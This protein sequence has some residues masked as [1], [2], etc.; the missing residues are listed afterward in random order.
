MANPDLGFSPRS[1]RRRA[2]EPGSVSG[3]VQ[4][5]VMGLLELDLATG[6]E[7]SW[8]SLGFWVCSTIGSWVP[9]DSIDGDYSVILVG[10]YVRLNHGVVAA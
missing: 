9:F 2:L 5:L 10:F 7:V 1:A 8:F 3:S 6:E 4:R